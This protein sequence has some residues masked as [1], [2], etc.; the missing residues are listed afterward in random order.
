M[1]SK[2][3]CFFI[4]FERILNWESLLFFFFND[5]SPFLFVVLSCLF[6][7]FLFQIRN[8]TFD[9]KLT[10]CDFCVSRTLPERGSAGA[11]GQQGWREENRRSARRTAGWRCGA[12]VCVSA[13]CIFDA[14][15]SNVP[16]IEQLCARGN[17]SRTSIGLVN[18]RAIVWTLLEIH[19][20]LS[21]FFLF[22]LSSRKV[23]LCAARLQRMFFFWK[24]S[25]HKNF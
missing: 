1:Q 20:S 8:A 4:S 7:F 9:V 17:R 3:N 10:R 2:N 25:F 23:A 14:V 22:E 6:F 13:L 19:F 24:G 15:R 11:V 12:V 21:F 18:W 16:V 5:W